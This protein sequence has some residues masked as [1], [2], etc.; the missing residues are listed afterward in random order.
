[1]RTA[2]RALL[3]G[4]FFFAFSLS[5]TP[6]AETQKALFDLSVNGVPHGVV[7]VLLRPTD[8]LIGTA[9]L[10]K[11]GLRGFTGVRETV[12]GSEFVSL[13]S[14]APEITFASD[15]AGLALRITASPRLLGRTARDLGSGHP[16]DVAFGGDTSAF[17][18]Y[19]LSTRNTGG[20][21]AAAELGVSRGRGRF[22][23]DLW[24]REGEGIAR[25]LS[26]LVI[27]DRP[28]LRSWVFGDEQAISAGRLGG[29][30]LL[31]GVSLVRDFG[32]DP[33]LHRTPAPELSGTLATP[34]TV[35]VY[36]NGLLARREELPAGEFTL[37]NLPLPSG[38]GETRLVVRDAF[39][40]ESATS[41]P[42]YQAAGL[43]APGLPEY[44][45]HLGFLREG[46]GTP[47][48]SYRGLAFLGRYRAG[49]SDR[50]TLGGSLEAS[51]DLANGGA[52]L[53]LGL[54][55]G[56]V[57][58]EAAV[59]AAG[60]RRGFAGALSYSFAGRRLS[61][62]GGVAVRSARF[63]NLGLP[64]SADRPVLETEGSCG[65]SAGRRLN[66]SLQAVHTAQRDGGG[67]NRAQLAAHL[68]IGG[69]AALLLLASGS[70]EIGTDGRSRTDRRLQATLHL[71][72]PGFTAQ[73]SGE[74]AT[75]GLH[76]TVEIQKPLPAGTGYGYRFLAG[77]AP[78]QTTT[79]E[80]E[81]R[82]QGPFGLYE[83]FHQTSAE[84]GATSLH[85]AGGLVAIG[86][87]VFPTRPVQSGFALVQVP[88]AAGVRVYRSNQEVGRT[89]AR[90][91]FLVPDLLAE[92]GNRLKIADQ[93]LPFD[94]TVEASE[95]TVAPPQR[96]GMVVR[97][98][99]RRLRAFQG[100]LALRSASGEVAPYPGRL[101]VTAGGRGFTSPVG[102]AGEIYLE[103][104]PPGDHAAVVESDRGNCAFRLT[105]PAGE[106]AFANLGR[107]VCVIAAEEKR[108]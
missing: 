40:R 18:N 61:A 95:R 68:Q 72:L 34:S 73:L 45:Y 46:L 43:L 85:V 93:D 39:G 96:G 70:R 52:Q 32:L 33:Y 86:G 36:V 20:L 2:L 101:T 102:T 106:T 47:G 76:S 75:G 60:A 104:V 17:L 22:L 63:A 69:R 8:I 81:L 21:D 71:P 56:E 59:S 53:A 77:R 3:L 35:E 37:R 80:G 107:L 82:Y 54:P 14:L 74:L 1:M 7:L 100:K 79:G 97:F 108:P 67:S 99:V 44:G 83:L 66:L 4:P 87:G 29:G 19:S 5:A 49:W 50:L 41:S 91:D 57:D 12:N 103:N 38:R 16:P 42:Y 90:G 15:P 92:Y 28:R 9:D 30:A 11:A 27:D 88:G 25:G 98:P 64:A 24:R 78:N 13:G 94:Y 26:R 62:G 48:S 6:A 55:A 31:G 10:E 105:V 58:L 65:L 89:G 51:A 84:G 23:S